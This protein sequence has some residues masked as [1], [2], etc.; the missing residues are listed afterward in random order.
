MG[1]PQTRAE[2]T[3]LDRS[4]SLVG[5]TARAVLILGGSLVRRMRL[6]ASYPTH[7]LPNARPGLLD[8]PHAPY[9]P[10]SG[11]HLTF[12]LTV[13]GIEKRTCLAG[14]RLVAAPHPRWLTGIA[15]AL[16]ALR[17]ATGRGDVI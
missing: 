9:W 11:C 7:D 16:S 6:T 17:R 8:P 14:I 13:A 4:L 2:P 3:R 12:L 10:L 15:L 5:A 1:L